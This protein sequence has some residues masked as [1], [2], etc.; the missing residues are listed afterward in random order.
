MLSASV[1]PVRRLSW[2]AF[3]PAFPVA[4]ATHEHTRHLPPSHVPSSICIQQAMMSLTFPH[5]SD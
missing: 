4:A 3:S 2:R 1:V 5:G